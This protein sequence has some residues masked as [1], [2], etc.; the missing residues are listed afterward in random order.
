MG[1][2][3]SWVGSG[4]IL[5]DPHQVSQVGAKPDPTRRI[6]ILRYTYSTFPPLRS[7]A[8]KLVT[9]SLLSKVFLVLIV[10]RVVE[11]LVATTSRKEPY[12]RVNDNA[13]DEKSSMERTGTPFP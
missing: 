1:Q 10:Q 11:H 9:A 3:E 4:Q 13:V 5:A 12:N 2:A 8:D 7:P 6:S